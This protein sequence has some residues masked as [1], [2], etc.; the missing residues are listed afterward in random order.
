[1][2]RSGR[3]AAAAAFACAALLAGGGT[4]AACDGGG[5]YSG[6]KGASYTSFS[7]RGEHHHH[8]G[9][10]RYQLLTVTANYLGVDPSTLMSDLKTGQTL[11]Q[12]APAGKT[13]DGLAAAFQDALKAKLDAKVAAGYMTSD[14]EQAILTNVSPRL[15]QLASWLWTKQFGS[16]E[17]DGDNH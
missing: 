15:Q 17:R 3:N 12:I 8:R 9:F 13:A 7:F 2:I 1:M 14:E 16:S 4:A 6:V 10:W 5:H 11:A